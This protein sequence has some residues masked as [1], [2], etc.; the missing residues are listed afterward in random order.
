MSDIDHFHGPLVL[1]DVDIDLDPAKREVVV[2]AAVVVVV[3][4][5]GAGHL[6]VMGAVAAIMVVVM[7]AVIAGVGKRFTTSPPTVNTAPRRRPS[8]AWRLTIYHHV[9]AGRI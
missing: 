6:H 4:D 5:L 3:A 2:A 1:A 9:V 8:G 7:E